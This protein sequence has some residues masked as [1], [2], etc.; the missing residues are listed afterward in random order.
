[1]S[2]LRALQQ[3]MLQAVLVPKPSSLDVI[4]GDAIADTHSR[5]A[6]YRHGYRMR[7]RDGLKNEFP[8]LRSM[9]GR[10]FDG[11]LDAFIDAH[12]ST[13][14]NIRWHGA[15]VTGFLEQAR[16]D[17]PQWA[18]A[19]RLDWA[20]STA[21]DATDESSIGMEQLAAVEPAS[22]A[23]LQLIPQTQLQSLTCAYNVEAFRRAADRGGARPHLRR[24]AAPRRILVWRHATT[25]HYRR[26]PEDE[27]QVLDAARQ[28]EPFAA[29]CAILA[30]HHG[31]TAAMARMVALLQG[32][33][34]AGLLRGL[35]VS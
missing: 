10:A 7:L 11:L 13:H 6:V 5:L 18:E 34:G 27:W 33:A 35:A 32:W 1:M 25:V 19:A 30:G 16:G 21:F 17:K 24:H 3:Q 12:P 23:S 29:L 2:A 9:A 28:G 4:R 22:W 14:Y 15:G 20:L 31:E 8:A 26:L